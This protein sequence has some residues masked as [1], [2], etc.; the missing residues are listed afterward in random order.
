MEKISARS[1]IASSSSLYTSSVCIYFH[2]FFISLSVSLSFAAA[3]RVVIFSRVDVMKNIFKVS[4][5]EK[6]SKKSQSLR[7]PF[8]FTHFFKKECD[9]QQRKP[10]TELRT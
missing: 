3:A 6:F 8:I 5:S 7:I 10:G 9:T 4:D 1:Q 2:R